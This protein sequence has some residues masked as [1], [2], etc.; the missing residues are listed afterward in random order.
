[1]VHLWSQKERHG[2]HIMRSEMRLDWPEIVRIFRHLWNA[3]ATVKLIRD[4][5]N[6]RDKNGRSQM[7]TNHIVKQNYTAQEQQDRVAVRAQIIN[8]ANTLRINIPNTNA[9]S[10]APPTHTAAPAVQPAP[11]SNT[12]GT[13]T[14]VQAAQIVP[15]YLQA[16]SALSTTTVPAVNPASTYATVP[17]H[18]ISSRPSISF[19][20]S[21]PGS[22]T[23]GRL[24]PKFVLAGHPDPSED[25]N[26][27]EPPTKKPATAERMH[28]GRALSSV[29]P[30]QQPHTIAG[31]PN[32]RIGF[33][34]GANSQGSQAATQVGASEGI[35][36]ASNSPLVMLTGSTGSQS[37][38]SDQHKQAPSLVESTAAPSAH[39]T[40]SQTAA[41]A[42]SPEHPQ[43]VANNTDSI[44]TLRR[45][46]VGDSASG[47]TASSLIFIA[48][49]E[50]WMQQQGI[51]V[52]VGVRSVADGYGNVG[53][54]IQEYTHP[55]GLTGSVLNAGGPAQSVNAGPALNGIRGG[56]ETAG[57]SDYTVGEDDKALSEDERD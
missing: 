8:A 9:P 23:S 18:G 5:Y 3:E 44:R 39:V 14:T 13:S 12:Q 25:Q 22:S 50:A 7:W 32:A 56:D 51:P 57:V 29:R 20:R 19:K 16:P 38:S 1:M 10:T 40:L 33:I 15:T 27:S 11:S 6:N 17:S 28:T 54:G 49:V 43:A 48:E 52:S 35:S 34:F 31:A 53:G 37:T 55:G 36:G 21:A 2:S 4:D 46:L 26:T 30:A 45:H 42:L 24:G 41:P 47:L